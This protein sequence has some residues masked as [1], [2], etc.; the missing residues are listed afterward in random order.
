MRAEGDVRLVLLRINPAYGVSG[1]RLT[2]AGRS[3]QIG[4]DETIALNAPT[5]VADHPHV[6][7]IGLQIYTGT[8]ILDAD[9]IVQNTERALD[10]ADQVAER[11]GIDVRMVDLGG[12]IGLAYFEG[13]ADPDE[14]TF[15]SGINLATRKFRAKHPA[16]TIAMEPGRYLVGKAGTC[17]LRVRYVKE[18]RGDRYAITDGGS[19]LNMV[20]IGL[21]TY[22]KRNFPTVLLSA[23]R[24]LDGKWSVTG[25]LLTPTDVLTKQAEMPAL[26]PGD[27]VGI[28]RMG[29]YGPTTSIAYMNGQRYPAEILVLNGT[30]HLVRARDTPEDLL[31]KQILV[32]FDHGQE[33]D[34]RPAVAETLG[35]DASTL[36]EDSRLTD[37]LHVDSLSMVELVA[38][39][40]DQFKFAADPEALTP[41][42]FAT[43]GSLT[44]YVRSRLHDR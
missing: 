37:D 40:E 7:I 22:V 13:E 10:L 33:I 15:V 6:D 17:V 23:D 27:L 44:A 38:R 28:L 19:N 8:R 29:A 3:R 30:A 9:V 12:G 36:G 31:R 20:A 32:D 26:R 4:I 21:G 16:A 1:D 43:V 41:N 34:I 18:S 39:L 25:P 24:P 42:D 2:M 35:R 14:A 5:T 11:L